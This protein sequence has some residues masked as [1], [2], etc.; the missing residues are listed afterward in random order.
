MLH[1]RLVEILKGEL[2]DA[3]GGKI[4]HVYDWSELSSILTHPQTNTMS[5]I[6][7]QSNVGYYL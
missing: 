2:K 3:D 1:L 7:E 6:S 4:I 5:N